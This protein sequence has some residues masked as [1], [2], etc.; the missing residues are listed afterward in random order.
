M[1]STTVDNE[2]VSIAI[3]DSESV[4][5]PSGE[6]WRVTI[7][8]GSVDSNFSEGMAATRVNGEPMAVVAQGASSDQA[9]A[10]TESVTTVVTGGDTI[11]MD[12]D[13]MSASTHI[14]GF[15]VSE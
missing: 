7:S 12:T 9:Y 10:T 8:P 3:S 11:D 6:V 1:V 2:P 15:V 4:S 14:G 13:S 5:V